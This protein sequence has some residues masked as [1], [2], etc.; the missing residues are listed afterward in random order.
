MTWIAYFRLR[1]GALGDADE[2]ELADGEGEPLLPP[3]DALAAFEA[4]AANGFKVKIDR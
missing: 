4:M 3:G 1:N 2:N